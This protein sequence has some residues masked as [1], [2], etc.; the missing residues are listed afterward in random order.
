MNI[1]I[2]IALVVVAAI[3]IGLAVVLTRKAEQAV[4]AAEKDLQQC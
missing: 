3:P 4:R 1:G 2:F